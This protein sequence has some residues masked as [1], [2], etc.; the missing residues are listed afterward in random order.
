MQSEFL[1]SGY[2]IFERIFYSIQSFVQFI[3]DFFNQR[4]AIAGITIADIKLLIA[5]LCFFLLVSIFY[6]LFQLKELERIRKVKIIRTV[7]Q[8]SVPQI[9]PRWASIQEHMKS[10]N[11]AE[12][13]LAIIEA[14]TILDDI[15]RR[16]GYPGDTLGE[17]LKQIEPSDFFTLQRAWEGH[18]VRNRIA[19]EGLAFQLPYK[20][21]VTAI[22]H[23]EAV[24]KEFNLI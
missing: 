12:W 9:D 1:N 24:F 14:D 17:R 2:S 3:N 10:D 21:A 6:L 8:E 15:T 19:H 13:R 7:E 16:M 18:K 23:F 4:A 20:D 22:A 5:V 11:P